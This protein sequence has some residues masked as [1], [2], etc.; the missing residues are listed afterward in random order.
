VSAGVAITVVGS[1]IVSSAIM[2]EAERT[3]KH[4]L[5][6]ARAIHAHEI[7]VL[8]RT[9]EGAVAGITIPALLEAGDTTRLLDFLQKVRSHDRIDF[10]TLAD[11]DGRVL[12]R[13]S[14]SA[15]RG[16]DATAIQ[17]VAIALRERRSVAGS[18]VLD[19]GVLERENPVLREQVRIPLTLPDRP[20]AR[21]GRDLTSG[22]VMTAAAPVRD[23]SARPV[24]VLYAG[25]L[26]NHDFG[27]V[28]QVWRELYV[29]ES[30]QHGAGTVTIFLDDVRISTNVRTRTGGRALGTRSSDEVRRAVLERGETWN[31]RTHVLDARYITAYQPIRDLAGE[32]IGM[33]YVG[34]PEASYAAVPATGSSSPSW[35]SRASGS[36]W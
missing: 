23:G 9:L 14:A 27:I 18:E 25:R 8:E 5:A 31:G 16:D 29:E 30:Q 33:L 2:A 12:F 32:T 22:L 4:D 17:A 15:V 24:G 26:L 7:R 1:Y 19:T 21:D 10:L 36:C 35:P 3:V 6:I 34:V 11:P 20:D 28:D 13:T